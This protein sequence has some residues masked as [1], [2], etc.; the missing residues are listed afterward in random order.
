MLSLNNAKPSGKYYNEKNTFSAAQGVCMSEL[1][2]FSPADGT[3]VPLEQVPDPAFSEKMLGDGIAVVPEKG[4]TA[5]PFDGKVVSVH[6]ALHAVVVACGAV[7]VLIHVGVETV[8][9]QGKGF[10]TLV[11]VGDN[12]KKG[13]KLTEFDPEFLAK[14]TPCNWVI[15]IVTSPDRAKINKFPAQ[16]VK[17]GQDAVFSVSEALEQTS[18]EENLDG[19]WLFSKDIIITDLNGLHARPAGRLAAAAKKYAFP[20]QLLCAEKIADAKSLVAVM[21][22]SLARGNTVRL[23]A[24][25]EEAAAPQ[26]LQELALL[27]SNGAGETET[28]ESA[29]LPL[30]SEEEHASFSSNT[31]P[32]KALTACGGIAR[33]R[34]YIFQSDDMDFPQT[35]KDPQEQ[36]QLLRQ[37]LEAVTKDFEAEIISASSKT[38]KEILQAHA[39]LAKDPFLAE[40]TAIQIQQGASAAFAF[41]QAIDAAINVLHKTKNRFLRERISDF[42]DLRRRVLFKLTSGDI[43]KPDFPDPCIVV[44][45]ELLPSDLSVFDARVRGVLLAYG[46]PTAH[47]SILLRNMGLPSLVGAGEKILS[48]TEGTEVALN[49]TDGVV[50][51]N[52]DKEQ[53]AHIDHLLALQQQTLLQNMQASSSPACTTD[54]T[55]V[56]VCGNASQEREALAAAQNGADG[57]GLVRTEF[58]FFQAKEPPT[59]EQQLTLYQNITAALNGKPVTLRTLDVGGD[60]PVPYMPLPPEENPIVGLRGIRN[61]EAYR[62]IFLTQ[63][64]AMLRVTPAGLVRI[65]LPMVSFVDEF[66][67]YKNLIE[68]EKQRLGIS[69][70]IQIGMMVEVPAAAL[71]ARQFANEADFFSIGT[72]DLTQYA[73]AID[74]GHKTLCTQADHL[75]PAVLRLIEMTCRGAQ[76]KSRPVA[77][78]G[79]MAGDLQAVPLLIGLG[80]TELAVGASAIAQVK[81]LVRKLDK[82]HCIQA[83]Q[84]A[85]ELDNA[86]EVRAWVKK[87]FNL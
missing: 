21:G 74:R 28:E 43:K 22:L 15:L 50:Y 70:P 19:R 65:M 37:A 35:A 59:Q 51:V 66:S 86:A 11:K 25:A 30:C 56:F 13:Q 85:C 31:S 46:S 4:F 7:E 87:E 80:V 42:K 79:A 38:A 20:I 12:V 1:H 45:D 27:L 40:Q 47:V 18:K 44:A 29:P 23:R 6:K 67:Y 75:H 60:K 52:P 34:A 62:D 36:Q 83:A 68:T 76:T 69:A 71:L 57:L 77:V 32:C 63:I 39:E 82:K 17:A 54:G 26:A 61:Y 48:I 16:R 55:R 72:N 24:P 33:G 41:S 10:K 84:H 58:S 64:R 14:Q 5:A 8:G 53:N 78:C 3:L 73:L 9:L 2:V 81:A 49:A